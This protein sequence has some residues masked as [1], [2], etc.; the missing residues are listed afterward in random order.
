MSSTRVLI[1]FRFR[2]SLYL[3]IYIY[4]LV[5]LAVCSV[6]LLF[7][8]ID[9][10]IDSGSQCRCPEQTF[11]SSVSLSLSLSSLYMG[12]SP[13]K[14]LLFTFRLDVVVRYSYMFPFSGLNRSTS[15]KPL[16]SSSTTET[17]PDKPGKHKFQ[18]WPSSVDFEHDTLAGVRTVHVYIYI[19]C[20]VIKRREG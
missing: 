11:S 14:H 7:T 5:H 19:W 16:A 4:I 13:Y 6:P 3:S 20:A 17:P 1:E 8:P 9:Q 12:L 15:A 2:L 18:S 10:L